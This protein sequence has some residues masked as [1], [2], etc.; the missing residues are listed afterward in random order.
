ME[1]KT[2]VG[3]IALWFVTIGN[4]SAIPVIIDNYVGAEEYGYGDVIGNRKKFDTLSADITRTNDQLHID[5]ITNFAGR[6]DDGLFSPYTQGNIGIGYGDLFLNTFWDPYGTA[7]YANDNANN[8][9]QWSFA[10]ALDNAW[11][12]GMSAG[13][14]TGTLYSLPAAPS[15]RID[16]ILISD[17]LMTGARY[18]N[19]QEVAVNTGSSYISAVGN[20]S[21]S[22]WSIDKTSKKLSFWIDVSGTA[23]AN[24]SGVAIHWGPTCGNDVIE[25]YTSVPEPGTLALLSAGLLA[26]PLIRRRRPKPTLSG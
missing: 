4:V 13:G 20:N 12:D 23:L 14:G 8:G 16:S 7:P 2:L 25:G 24:S 19:G 17:E 11:W 21:N 1:K 15:R 9:T 22:S 10:F 3:V 26:I 6:G 18:R 5:I